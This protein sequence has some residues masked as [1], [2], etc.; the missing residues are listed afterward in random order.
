MPEVIADQLLRKCGVPCPGYIARTIASHRTKL[1]TSIFDRWVEEAFVSKHGF[2]ESEWTSRILDKAAL[3]LSFS[4]AGL[5]KQENLRLFA[6]WNSAARAFE[7]FTLKS[8]D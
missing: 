1:A 4:G 2:S 3:P 6:Y 8:D 7:R 5:R